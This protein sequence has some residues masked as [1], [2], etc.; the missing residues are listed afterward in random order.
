MKEPFARISSGHSEIENA[1]IFLSF[2]CTPSASAGLTVERVKGLPVGP[3]PSR[4][5]PFRYA[6]SASV[7]VSVEDPLTPNSL[8]HS[9]FGLEAEV[10]FHPSP[11]RLKTEDRFAVQEFT[12]Y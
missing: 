6:P 7:L 12:S 5:R 8:P 3:A 9:Q 10:C 1:P 11:M 4:R 2:F